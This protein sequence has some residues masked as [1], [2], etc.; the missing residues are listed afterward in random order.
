MLVAKEPG[1]GSQSARLPFG[2]N[3]KGNDPEAG[4]QYF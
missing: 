2:F 1:R 3:A 4:R